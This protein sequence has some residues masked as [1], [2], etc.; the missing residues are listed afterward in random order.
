MAHPAKM[1]RGLAAR[2]YEHVLEE[3]WIQAGGR[4]IDPF[5]GIAGTAFHAMV[6][7]LVW[8]GVELEPR[9]V[10]W[11]QGMDCDGSTCPQCA[12]EIKAAEHQT[13]MFERAPH[14]FAGNI[15][16][17]EK[18]G[19]P[20]TARLVQGDSRKLREVLSNADLSVTSPPYGQRTVHGQA[21]IDFSRSELRDRTG[22][23]GQVD[24]QD[25]YGAEAGNLGNMPMSDH[26]LAVSS[27]PF[28]NSGHSDWHLDSSPERLDKMVENYQRGGGGLSREGFA[29]H[30]RRRQ[31][32]YGT[33]DGQL[34][35]MFPGDLDTC[36]S[37]PP[38]PQPH[39][40]GGGIN[41]EG[42]SKDWKKNDMKDLVGNRTYQAR[43]A[44]RAEGN[45]EVLETGS[46]RRVLK[47]H[48]V[49]EPDGVAYLFIFE[50]QHREPAF[51]KIAVAGSVLD[52]LAGA[53]MPILPVAFNDEIPTRN[54]EVHTIPPSLHLPLIS[55]LLGVQ[56]QSERVFKIALP[57][58]PI[59]TDGTVDATPVLESVRLHLKGIKADR[60]L[61]LDLCGSRLTSTC[62]GTESSKPP[63]S[64]GS[65]GHHR[66]T[67]GLTE[68]GSSEHLG[69]LGTLN[70][71]IA[72]ALFGVDGR[73]AKVNATVSTGQCHFTSSLVDVV[74]QTGTEP[75]SDLDSIRLY[76]ETFATAITDHVVKIGLR[77]TDAELVV[78]D[79]GAEI[80][81][82]T[83][84]TPDGSAENAITLSAGQSKNGR[85][86]H[87][88]P[89][90]QAGDPQPPETFW[91]ASRTI[92]EQ[93]FD[94]LKPGGHAV[95]VTGDFV[96]D[97]R[98]VRFGEQWRQL[99][100]AVG[101]VCL[102][103][104]MASKTDARGTQGLL[105]G[106]EVEQ[107]SSKI[108]FFRRNHIDNERAAIHWSSI[109]NQ[110]DYLTQAET[111]LRKEYDK[112]VAAK[113]S[114]VPVTEARILQVAQ[115]TA[116]RE[117]GAPAHDTDI[118]I[119]NEDVWCFLR[120]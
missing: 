26:A 50:P 92:L 47:S 112:R 65:S 42:Y 73:H 3:Q 20:G 40:G 104:H 88:I 55:D 77:P 90:E 84:S 103:H 101:F 18:K 110:T 57:T 34:G 75:P 44:D 116:W 76:I 33:S 28:G 66:S 6:H 62:I 37:S 86:G 98:R 24:T 54:E 68:R 17:W 91:S 52:A 107:Q 105:D 30:C 109:E 56:Q 89:N 41:V 9:F 70:G 106:G 87:I 16:T 13:Q 118:A 78:T 115:K 96:R 32:G 53:G 71:A 45:L 111:K 102:H 19:L 63:R 51:L 93:L 69:R 27:P 58:Q 35:S 117:G 108:S 31:E 81:L 74:T 119:L 97:R 4:V 64:A 59:T 72:C 5:G 120:P 29:E 2:I 22:S 99:C 11:G 8:Q 1:A 43:G 113:K 80:R 100:E 39:A 49:A 67:A 60:A 48:Q 79:A 61:P 38:Y 7:G 94:V 95:F 23:G 114:A 83:V 10:A 25:R 82:G 46:V 14:R 21:G 36:I 12:K 85:H 15:E